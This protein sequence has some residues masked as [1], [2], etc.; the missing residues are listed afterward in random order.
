MSWA[1]P[2]DIYLSTSLANYLDSKFFLFPS[3]PLAIFFGLLLCLKLELCNNC[4]RNKTFFQC[5]GMPK[6]WERSGFLQF[7]YFVLGIVWISSKYVVYLAI[8]C[9]FGFFFLI[10]Y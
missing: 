5:V 4:L 1:G 8:L 7:W 2:E 10:P 6:E 3:L 9:Y